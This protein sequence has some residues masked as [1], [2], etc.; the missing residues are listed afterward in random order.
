MKHLIIFLLSCK[1]IYMFFMVGTWNQL[2]DKEISYRQID[3]NKT[4]NVE[5]NLDKMASVRESSIIDSIINEISL[6]QAEVKLNIEDVEI[7]EINLLPDITYD[8]YEPGK[9]CV[10]NSKFQ[11]SDGLLKEI[12][13]L[14]NSYGARTSFYAVSIEDNMTLGYNPDITFQTASTVKAPFVLYA[15][16]KVD[17]GKV[18]LEEKISYDPR[19][20]IEG[21]GLVSSN[22]IGSRYTLEELIF[23]TI[24]YSDNTSYNM[25]HNYLWDEGYNDMLRELGCKEFY[26]NK[27]YI[28]GKGSTRSAAL[29]WQEIYSFSKQCESGQTYLDI[30]K[31]TEHSYIR[32]SLGEYEVASKYG[33]IQEHCHDTGIVFADKPYIIAIMTDNGGNWSGGEQIM[34]ISICIDKVMKEYNQWQNDRIRYKDNIK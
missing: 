20:Y 9:I 21:A 22:P 13:E 31:D 23:Y 5:P 10:K 8:I 34:K 29:I 12:Y 14:I 3:Y 6:G 30:L 26:L 24:H 2:V 19:F 16:K 27:G 11:I 4:I 33:W 7:N 17:G 15:L 28:W 18:S 25:L 32:N 1:V